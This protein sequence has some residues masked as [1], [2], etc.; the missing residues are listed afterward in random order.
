M[1]AGDLIPIEEVLSEISVRVLDVLNAVLEN[2]DSDLSSVQVVLEDIQ[3]VVSSMIHPFLSTPIKDY[4]VT[5][6][7]LFLILLF[8]ILRQL[9]YIC[10][11][12]W[13]KFF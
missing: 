9:G 13:N 10:K 8:L 7:L 6:G 5:E 4:T 1:T 11:S 12:L 2:S 3:V